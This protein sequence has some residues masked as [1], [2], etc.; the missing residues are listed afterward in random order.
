MVADVIAVDGDS[1]KQISIP[2]DMKFV[3]MSGRIIKQ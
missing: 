2:E 3:I 1:L